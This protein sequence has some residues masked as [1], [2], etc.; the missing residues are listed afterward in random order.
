M[1]ALLGGQSRYGLVI[2]LLAVLA[3]NLLLAMLIV[4]VTALSLPN[5]VS[6]LPQ[7]R[8]IT[9][10]GYPLL[11]HILICLG[12]ILFSALMHAWPLRTIARQTAIANILDTNAS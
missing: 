8:F 10:R 11:A 7:L 9:L 4:I 3:A 1:A 12:F 2:G 5:G 6:L